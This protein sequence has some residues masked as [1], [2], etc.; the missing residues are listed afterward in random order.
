[1]NKLR[2]PGIDEEDQD[3]TNKSLR[4]FKLQVTAPDGLLIITSDKGFI[5][6]LRLQHEMLKEMTQ[7]ILEEK[8]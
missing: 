8:C 5:Y 4:G 6:S 2:V 7:E 3:H 1:M